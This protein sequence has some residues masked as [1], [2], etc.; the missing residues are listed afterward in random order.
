[1]HFTTADL[2]PFYKNSIGME[3]LMNTILNHSPQV[4][5]GNYPPYNIVEVDSD[6]YTVEIAVAGFAKDEIEITSE[7]GQLEI[8]GDKTSDS[9]APEK[10]FLF[11]GISNKKFIRVFNLAEYVEVNSANIVDGIL[12]IDLERNVPNQMKPK[13]IAID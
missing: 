9:D 10:T 5:S 1:M 3:R 8:K 2:A 11:Q 12:Q 6:H 7:N 4:N 13:T